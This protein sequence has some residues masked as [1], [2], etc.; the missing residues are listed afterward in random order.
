M[1]GRL[2]AQAGATQIWGDILPLRL[3]VQVILDK[4]TSVPQFPNL[5]NGDNTYLR[6]TVNIKQSDICDSLVTVSAP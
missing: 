4:I 1:H 6:N 5:E 3:T 2:T